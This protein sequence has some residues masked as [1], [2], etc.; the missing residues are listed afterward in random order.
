MSNDIDKEMKN[1]QSMKST[2]D[3]LAGYLDML[4]ERFD[5]DQ[6]YVCSG[7]TDV[8]EAF[9][10]WLHEGHLI[11]V[12][13]RPGMGKTSLVQQISEHVAIDK[14]VLFYTL[15]MSSY[16]LV[17]R[18]IS[19]R[20]GIPVRNLKTAELSD[21]DFQKITIA[22]NELIN[23]DLFIDDGV[24]DV[25]V[26]CSKTKKSYEKINANSDSKKL[27]LVI[28]DYLQLAMGNGANKTLEIGYIST[29]LKKL[30][31][32]IQVPVVAIAQLN[33]NLEQRQDKRPM[34]SDLRESGQIEQDADSI[35]FV[36][37][38]EVYNEN[39]SDKGVA[40]IICGKNRHGDTGTVRM[41]FIGHKMQFSNLVGYKKKMVND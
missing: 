40:E 39:S 1:E 8:D 31:K 22:V 14:T 37:R 3:I 38:D 33:R 16:E 23:I 9:G 30:A 36:Y 11:I 12:A 13:A 17:E 21:D 4:E 10:P 19:R 35:F 26:I 5:G 18:S 41:A 15:E 25:D 34:L 20:S 32:A 29:Q 24:Y 2:R 28:V 6:K 7:F 27:G